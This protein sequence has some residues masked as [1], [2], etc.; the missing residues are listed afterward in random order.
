[1]NVLIPLAAVTGYAIIDGVTPVYQK[2]GADKEK[3][4]KSFDATLLFRLAKNKQYLISTLLQGVGW[5]LGLVALRVFPVFLVQSIIAASIILTA[6]TERFITHHPFTKHT[7]YSI[8]FVIIGLV[9]LSISA[10]PSKGMVKSNNV[11]LVIEIAPIA[12]AIVG[13]FFLFLKGKSSAIGLSLMGGAGFGGTALIGRI[14]TYPSPIW[15]IVYD[16]M[17]AALL[18]YA[19][20]AQ[21]FYTVALQRASGT[22]TNSLMIITGTLLPAIIGFS[23][24]NDNIRSGYFL[25]V[26]IGA[27][28]VVIGSLGVAKSDPDLPDRYI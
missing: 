27:L 23:F 20:L 10:L 2:I 11:Q 4:S 5:V 13:A 28:L 25:A 22:M 1:M 16:P 3:R 19:I 14:I 12:L 8:V 18:G 9:L 7:Y 21:F 6:L 24:L 26:V 15:Q 17:L